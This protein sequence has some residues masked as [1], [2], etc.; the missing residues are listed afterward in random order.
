MSPTAVKNDLDQIITEPDELFE[1]SL[2][3]AE[4]F[5]NMKENYFYF[6]K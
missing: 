6:K 5:E 4:L 1:R 2:R 3:I